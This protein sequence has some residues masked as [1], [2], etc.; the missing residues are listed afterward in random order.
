MDPG[1]QEICDGVWLCATATRVTSMSGEESRTVPI[2]TA[3]A[4]WNDPWLER[5]V[6]GSADPDAI[7]RAVEDFC[8][9]SVGEPVAAVLFYA[10]SQGC[11]FG[12]RLAGGRKIVLKAYPPSRSP[13]FL[14]AAHRVQSHLADHGYPC[15]RPLTAPLPLAHGHAMIMD[16]LEDGNYVDAHDPAVRRAMAEALARLI[17]LTRDLVDLAGL[18]PSGWTVL[19]PDTLYPTPHSPIFDLEA[20][21]AGAAWIDRLAHRARE[22][23]RAHH[24]GTI[25]IGHT[26]WA[27]KDIR[28]REGAVRAIY[29]WD[30]LRRDLE[31]VIVGEAA[32]GFTNTWR[33][34]T[35]LAPA[36]DEMRAF[37]EAYEQARGTLF[38]PSERTTLGAVATYAAA[39]IS[40]LEHSRDPGAASFPPGSYRELLTTHGEALQHL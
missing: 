25:V 4:E 15:P 21:A 27:V 12:L 22:A 39:Y 2:A 40:R 34:P 32:R 29:D 23:F 35:R 19:A 11:V 26:D 18:D 7:L 30:S 8:V 36:L 33:F 20:T 17:A 9:A 3:I 10:A 13:L 5:A 1:E 28:F 24:A 31:T 37:V 16:L 38:S 6:F 14:A